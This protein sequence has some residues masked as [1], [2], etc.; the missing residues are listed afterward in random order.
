MNSAAGCKAFFRVVQRRVAS[1]WW[2]VASQLPRFLESIL[3]SCGL[4]GV[5]SA[6]LGSDWREDTLGTCST[7][8]CRDGFALARI[9]WMVKARHRWWKSH[10]DT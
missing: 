10:G 5:F 9:A 8:K 2:L 7:G 4:A 1:G 3:I 6:I